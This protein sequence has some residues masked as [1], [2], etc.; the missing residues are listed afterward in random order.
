MAQAAKGFANGSRMMTEIIDDGNA[1]H[2][3]TNLLSAFDAFKFDERYRKY[4]EGG[5][6]PEVIEA[7]RRYFGEAI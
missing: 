4:M 2:L 7:K 6:R 1:A 5:Y 3:S